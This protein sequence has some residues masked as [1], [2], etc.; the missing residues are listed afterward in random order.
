MSESAEPQLHF[1]EYYEDFLAKVRQL[2]RKVSESA[3]Q[4]SLIHI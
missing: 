3:W 2:S 4:L 1:L